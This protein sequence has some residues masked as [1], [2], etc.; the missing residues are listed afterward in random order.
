MTKC[1][2]KGEFL[3]SEKVPM[4]AIFVESDEY[5]LM[6]K[7]HLE[8]KENRNEKMWVTYCENIC[9]SFTITYYVELLSG[10]Y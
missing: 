1:N 9:K 4:N 6:I 3:V 5:K 2:A 7:K 10:Q 8:C